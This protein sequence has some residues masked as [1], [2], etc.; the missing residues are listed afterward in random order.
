MTLE[1]PKTGSAK[2]CKS[3]DVALIHAIMQNPTNYYVNVHT[4]AFPKG[5]IRGQLAVVGTE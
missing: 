3:A 5:A 2:G 1:A 4:V